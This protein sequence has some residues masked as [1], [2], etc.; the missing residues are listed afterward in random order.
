MNLFEPSELLKSLPG[1]FFAALVARAGAVAAGGHDVINLGQGNPDLPTPAHIVEALQTAGADPQN[2]RYPPFRGYRYLKEAAAEFYSREYGVELDPDREVAVLF[3]GKTGL[4][5]VVQ[6]LLNPG[7]TALVPD[8]G[9]PDYWSGIALARAEMEM[10]PLTA[11][12][13]FLPDYSSIGLE[14]AAKAKLMF[15]NYPNNPTGAVATGEFFA[16]TVQ[17]ASRHNICVVHDFAYAAIGYEGQKPLSYLQTP[18]AKAQGIEI[19]TLSKTYNMAGWRVAF[20]VGNASVI[21][22][23]NLLQDHMYVSLFGAVQEAARAALLGPQTPVEENVARY[24]ARRN[25]LIQGLHNIGWE[26]EA[27]GG[28]FFAWL[29]VPKGYTSESFASLLLDKAHVVVAPG[30]GFG[31]YGEGYVRVGLVSD[32]ARLAEAVERIARLGIFHPKA[33]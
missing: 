5:E 26:A 10:M 2:H 19:Y 25:L 20:A 23:I 28:S 12:H 13:A 29:P 21:E 6:C 24:E 17:F 14:T 1:Q 27:P 15:L 18:G 31:A 30:I 11:E 3:G 7:D 22:S 16:E 4:V 9:Y 32:E 8:P 33:L